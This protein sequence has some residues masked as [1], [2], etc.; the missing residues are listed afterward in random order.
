MRQVTG[1]YIVLIIFLICTSCSNKQYQVLFQQKQSLSDTAYSAADSVPEYR[2]KSQDI[3]Q[4]RNLQDAKKYLVNT[5]PNIASNINVL[6][7]AGS[8]SG[9]PVDQTFQV[10]DDG[11]VM[12]PVIGSVQVA[13]LTRAEAQKKIE[14]IYRKNVLVNPII[15]V[16]IINLK[17]TMLGAVN[18]QGNFPLT[19]DHTTLIELIGAAGGLSEKADET[20]IEIIRGTQKNPKV[21]MVDLGDIRSVNDPRAVL[22]N[23]DII[24]IAENKRATRTDNLQNFSSVF[25]PVLILFNTA[26]IVLTLIRR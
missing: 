18:A 10:A 9:G 15:E 7:D 24:Y 22:Q 16:K 17:V 4:V 1:I 14:D 25:Q 13:G 12:L 21:I 20:H 23:G 8:T 6:T 19:K 26:L 5:T 2:I 11:N 3:L